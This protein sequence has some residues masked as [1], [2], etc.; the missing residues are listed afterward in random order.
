MSTVAKKIVTSLMS[1]AGIKVGGNNP[2]DIRVNDDRFYSRCLKGSVGLGESYM[3]GDWDVERIDELFTRII[4]GGLPSSRLA[5]VG[6]SWLDL[7]SK[8]VNLQSRKGSLAIAETHYDL[9][10][11]LYQKFL[12]PYNQYTCCFFNEAATLEEAEV[13]KLEMIC[14]KLD[15]QPDD[16]VLDIGCGWGGFSKYA[17][18]T[19]G[20]HVTGVSISTEQIAYA[21]EFTAGLRVDIV[22]ADYRDLP[23][24]YPAGHFDKVLICGMI[25]HVGYKNYRGIMKVIHKVIKDQG[26]FLLHTIGNSQNTTV[27]DPWLEKYIFRNSML[28]SIGQ[29][30]DAFE[31]IF[32]MQAWENYGHY[33]AP[34]LA[35]WYENFDR[36]WPDIE[37]IDAPRPFDERFRRMFDYYLLSCKAGFETEFINLWQ[38]VLTKKGLGTGVYPRVNLALP[39]AKTPSPAP[40]Q[41]SEKPSLAAV[42]SN[43][44]Q[45]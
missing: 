40:Q 19:R 38:I 45:G 36:N 4:R 32:V 26:Y 17:A 14:N 24:L 23:D 6:R 7:K 12:G 31:G 21:R 42:Q 30:A 33:Y 8:L 44:G 28:P 43:S 35:A 10:H 25:E 20:C 13:E 15:I 41:D 3:D 5:R 34:T 1:K 9:D 22:E 16:R 2:W 18:E 27:A 39:D 29:L 37:K 11:R